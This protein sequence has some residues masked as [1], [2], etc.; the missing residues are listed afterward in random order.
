MTKYIKQDDIDDTV[1]SEIA[2]AIKEEKL[3]VIPTDTVYGLVA[4][5]YNKDACEKIYEIKNRTEDKPLIVLISD[6]SML[7]DITQNINPVEQK[8]IDTFWPGPLTIILNKRNNVL[9][10]IITAKTEE[11]AVRLLVDGPA[12]RII[13]KTGIP[14]VAPSA[15]L[16]GSETGVKIEN[17]INQLGGKVDY[18]LDY[19]DIESDVTSTI[20]KVIDDEIFVIREGK[21]SKEELKKIAPLK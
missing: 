20:V 5:A 21:I 13:K 10:D 19:G 16:S 8:L 12:S 6:I 1:I 2:N 9:P 4:N 14:I 3:V 15:N 11:L 18:I 7:K 17:I